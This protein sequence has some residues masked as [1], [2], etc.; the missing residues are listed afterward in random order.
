MNMFEAFA[1]ILLAMWRSLFRSVAAFGLGCVIIGAIARACEDEHPPIVTSPIEKF[2]VGDGEGGSALTLAL[3]P[4]GVG[5]VA[6]AG[7]KNDVW[8]DSDD[9]TGAWHYRE[10]QWWKGHPWGDSCRPRFWAEANF[11]VQ[12]G[13]QAAAVVAY[14]I[15]GFECR[16]TFLIPSDADPIAPHWDVVTKIR[17]ISGRDVEEYGQFFAS[18]TPVNRRQSFW[19]WDESGELVK[20]ADRGVRHL[21]GYV[22]HPDAY[23]LRQGAI[24]HCP[25]GGGK[26]V[27]KWLRPLMASNASPAGWRSIVMI[28]A[29]HAASLAHGIEGQAMDYIL[30]P[31]PNQTTFAEKSE[32]SAHIRQVMLKSPGLPTRQELES[33]WE[34]FERSHE[35]IHRRASKIH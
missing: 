12:R 4:R 28:E 16:Q 32:F 18:Y 11:R 15:D 33:L 1:V 5:R 13:D 21:D 27:G 34:S 23:F 14:E 29:S 31:G 30:F 35:S 8:V 19:F 7:E 20:F 24:P 10:W 3:D 9:P 25:R 17:N 26:I 22:V 2:T 6:P